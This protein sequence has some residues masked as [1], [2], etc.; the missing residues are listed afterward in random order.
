MA[1]LVSCEAEA[2]SAGERLLRAGGNA[3]DGAVAAAFAQAVV[4][5]MMCG[6][7]GSALALHADLRTGHVT[8]INGEA[9]T[10]SRPVPAAWA[11]EFLGRVETFGR[12]ALTSEGNQMGPASVMVPGFVDAM[13]L[14]LRRYGSGRVGTHD[15][16]APATALARN[17]FELSPY[18]ARWWQ[19]GTAGDSHAS[20]PGYP[21]LAAKAA[22]YPEAAARY[23]HPDG[24]G[25]QAGERFAQPWI[26][27]I[28]D[29]LAS[30]GLG[31]F[32]HGQLGGLLADALEREESLVSRE[33]VTGYQA[34][35]TP[36]PRHTLGR[37]TL[38]TAPPP[39]PGIQVLQMLALAHRL[40]IDAT[41]LDADTADSL[42]KAMRASFA[43]NRYIK[44]T[45]PSDA[46]RV[47]RAVLSPDSLDAWADAIAAGDPVVV[48]GEA[49]GD[50]TTHVT[51]VDGDHAVC[52]THSTGSVG[53]SAYLVPELGYLLNNFTG[54][55]NPLPGAPD[56]LRPGAR[57][58]TG[59][60]LIAFEDE[61]GDGG[62]TGG[63]HTGGGLALAVG[64]PGG[65]RLITATFQVARS[66]LFAGADA[67]TAVALPRVH[68]EEHRTVYV[69]P[70]QH[71]A[72]AAQ[73]RSHGNDVAASDYMSRV[74]AVSRSRDGRL[75]SGSDPRGGGGVA[76]VP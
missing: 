30:A 26:A 38:F 20:R 34:L 75:S 64:A 71:A 66:V 5:P 53:G 28:L 47:T 70:A 35:E 74:Q 56:S 49:P 62:R 1:V 73:L 16:L 39:S 14:L 13:D 67:E 69:E 6:L 61:R 12:Y 18:L 25:Y 3:V 9:A 4:N 33:D 17:G 15:V 63:A 58:G 10:G 31:D 11:G 52:I 54:H 51:A 43:D 60:P 45:D 24:S 22:A 76:R 40:G 44:A 23:L 48:R 2:A 55:Y 46:D 41:E 50:G 37:H 32:L 29:R 65:S 68:S 42:A 7:G 72:L 36:A 8:A 19:T 57:I 21:T 59:A 27:D